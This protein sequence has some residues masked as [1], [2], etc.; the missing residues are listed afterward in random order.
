MKMTSKGNM[1]DSVSASAMEAVNA[2]ETPSVVELAEEFIEYKVSI[3]ILTY[4]T[5][6]VAVWGWIGNFLSFR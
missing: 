2:T 4:F 3:Y 1:S 6:P 5:V